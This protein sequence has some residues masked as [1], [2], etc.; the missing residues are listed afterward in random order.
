MGNLAGHVALALALALALTAG[1]PAQAHKLKVFAAVDAATVDGRVYFVGG[2]AASGAVITVEAPP[3]SP[4]ACLAADGDGR[5]RFEASSRADHVI[6]AD[7]GDGHVARFTIAALDLPA[8]LPAAAVAAAQPAAVA[9]HRDDRTGDSVLPP[10]SALPD[11]LAEAVAS[12]V[13]PLR[14]QLNDYQDQV[15][16]RD[17]VGGIG[18]IFGLAGI[19]LWLRAA[20][21]PRAGR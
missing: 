16:F 8:A 7:A 1:T 20:R 21:R 12:Q 13:R 6:A 2:T 11:M 18:Y 3:G 4:V 14:E 10:A 15:R 9:S 19:A 5:F 17:I